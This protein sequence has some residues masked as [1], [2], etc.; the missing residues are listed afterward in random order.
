MRQRV[1]STIPDANGKLV[2]LSNDSQDDLMNLLYNSHGNFV[3]L[4]YNS[5]D[6]LVSLSH[7][8]YSRQ[9][10]VY[11]IKQQSRQLSEYIIQQSVLDTLFCSLKKRFYRAAFFFH[12]TLN[13]QTAYT[14]NIKSLVLRIIVLYAHS[15]TCICMVLLCPVFY[16]QRKT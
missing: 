15:I 9:R 1:V 11:D 5:Q 10:K 14:T 12:K 16:Y 13:L 2:S 8:Q 7:K 6:N 4:S 3:S